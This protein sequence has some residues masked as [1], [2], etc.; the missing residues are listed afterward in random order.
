M[1][2]D[3]QR[4]VHVTRVYDQKVSRRPGSLVENKR[5]ASNRSK[6]S[7]SETSRAGTG[8]GEG[9][10]VHAQLAS[11]ADFLSPNSHLGAWSQATEK[12]DQL[13]QVAIQCHPGQ[14]LIE[15]LINS[16]WYGEFEQKGTIIIRLP[17]MQM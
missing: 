14:Q 5:I 3:G 15:T 6:K 16:Y 11:L 8:E 9:A 13:L 1:D 4:V 2:G 17:L 10:P 7:A 12:L